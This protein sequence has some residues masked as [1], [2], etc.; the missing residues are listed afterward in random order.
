MSQPESKLSRQIMNVI[1][2][3]GGFCFKVHGGP[4]TMAGVPDICAVYNGWSLW[5]ETK[6]PEGSAPTPI[7]VHQHGRIR[8]AGGV[9]IVARSVAYVE[10]VLDGLDHTG[11]YRPMQ[12]PRKTS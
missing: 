6:M 10:S 2:A 8:A 3:R 11:V 9:V 7:Q 4:M 1:R 12:R 5:I